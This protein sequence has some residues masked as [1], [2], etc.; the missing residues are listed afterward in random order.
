MHEGATQS[1]KELQTLL[2]KRIFLIKFSKSLKHA[3]L[4]PGITVAG[5]G[6]LRSPV[7]VIQFYVSQTEKYLLMSKEM[8][9][10]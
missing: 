7:L 10:F 2:E 4:Y 3:A 8:D 9:F 1:G 5:M 6:S